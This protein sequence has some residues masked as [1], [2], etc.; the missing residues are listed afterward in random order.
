MIIDLSTR[1]V[2]SDTGWSEATPNAGASGLVTNNTATIQAIIDGL[3][4]WEEHVLV[5]PRSNGRFNFVGLGSA[6]VIPDGKIITFD[7]DGAKIKL[8]TAL[9]GDSIF[10][11]IPTG[12]NGRIRI[13]G[14]GM[15]QAFG[16]PN[17]SVVSTQ[18]GATLGNF[19]FQCC[20]TWCSGYALLLD[21][22]NPSM[23]VKIRDSHISGAQAIRVTPNPSQPYQATSGM[24]I[25]QVSTHLE[26]GIAEAFYFD[27]CHAL[28]WRGG[29]IEGHGM[30]A[31]LAQTW[32]GA[33]MLHLRNMGY[34]ET[35]IENVWLEF[36][37]TTPPNGWDMVLD[38]GD[39]S[40]SVCFRGTNVGGLKAQVKNNN[41]NLHF[42]VRVS[43]SVPTDFSRWKCGTL[44]TVIR[45]DPMRFQWGQ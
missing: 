37:G 30:D 18:Q 13:K 23:W 41:A 31:T 29:S 43:G 35:L 15:M 10:K 6:I 36:G 19:L 22:I 26:T 9:A 11:I 34:H 4:E 33:S 45:E 40:A 8:C 12:V 27:G 5:F 14:F 21:K 24:L 3:S 32:T 2:V 1:G 20:V 39:G 7:G 25:D 28:Q 38:G 42:I 44:A 16:A 17:L